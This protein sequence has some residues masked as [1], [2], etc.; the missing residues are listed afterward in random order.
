MILFF[1]MKRYCGAR[2]MIFT[3]GDVCTLACAKLGPPLICNEEVIQLISTDIPLCVSA[4]RTLYKD[5]T[6][7][8]E[9]NFTS[10]AFSGG[11]MSQFTPSINTVI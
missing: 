6:I 2:A 11:C 9:G 3:A 1:F 4:I 10:D 5:A 8:G 7:V